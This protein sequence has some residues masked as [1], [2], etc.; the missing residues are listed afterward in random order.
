M[1]PRTRTTNKDANYKVYYSKKIPKQVRFPHRRKTVRRP[2]PVQQDGV[3]K[4]QMKFLPEMMR[5]ER[6]HKQRNSEE[7]ETEEESAVQEV[8]VAKND[9]KSTPVHQK[10]GRRRKSDDVQEDSASG[11][12]PEVSSSKRRR[13][14]AAPKDERSRTL[15]RQST[16]TQLADGRRP[17]F[18]DDEPDFRSVKRGSRAS[19][20]SASTKR[21]RDKK[22]RTLTQMIPCMGWLSKEE[23]EELSDL[24]T[25][26]K[27]VQKYNDVI[28]QP[29][30]ERGPV[31]VNEPAAMTE[32]V[33][34]YP[35]IEEDP[36]NDREHDQDD[37]PAEAHLQSF[38]AFQSVKTAANNDE[39]DYEPT[40]FIEAPTLRT[41]QTP[42]RTAKNQLLSNAPGSE[43][44]AKSRFSLLSTPEKRRVFE[45][46]S[47]QS[48]AESV[49]STQVSPQKIDRS[50]FRERKINSIVV[51][52]T[53]SKRQHVTF[54]EPTV[55]PAPPVHLRKFES[56]IQDSED[57]G[58]ELDDDTS[59]Q[60][61]S[62][63]SQRTL[64][65]QA[66]SADTQA[67]LLQIDR[68]CADDDEGLNVDYR[69]TPDEPEELLTRSIP[70]QP[71]PEL[72]GS[73]AP[74]I[75][76]DVGPQ[77]ESD[78]SSLASANSQ[79]FRAAESSKEL[80]PMLYQSH[81]VSQLDLTTQASILADD[82]PS[83]PPMVRP[84]PSDDLPSTPMVIR[85]ESS[86]EEE[87]ASEPIPPRT[88]QRYVP[89][90]PS[91]LIHQFTDLDGEPVQ[92]PRSPSAERDTQQS[93]SSKAEQQLQNEWLSYSQYIRA[94][95]PNSS[96]MHVTADP[97]SY[98]ARHPN[99]GPFKTSSSRMQYSQ[100]TTVDELTPKKNRTQRP[101][102]ANTTPHRAGTSQSF[103][104]PDKPPS[105]FIPS[106]FPSLSMAAM[107]GWSSPVM[108]KTQNVHGSSQVL[109]SLEDFSIPLPPPLEDD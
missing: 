76:D 5:Q 70:C 52:E 44:S 101:T 29:L 97:F 1:T 104:S 73:W 7:E 98:N 20:V 27:H 40:Q 47:S 56:T 22:Q 96:S 67:V 46:P 58:S 33:R 3:D 26:L 55:Q 53:P 93:H 10:K 99:P 63:D 41:R 88:V 13:R 45:I 64:R 107:E 4:R 65:G 61:P 30:I 83:T 68:A 50:A 21:E 105:L 54:Q 24:D 62:G 91:T 84:P 87:A 49:M 8:V 35:D 106:S 48:P 81:D 66:I 39:D 71:S 12:E 60:R 17:S 108:A 92:V 18:G 89:E 77:Y 85:D 31:E 82:I 100:A 34:Q 23:L 9:E 38:L 28:S 51:T 74:F 59:T 78:R 86:D 94:R 2:D 15:R 95:A 75:Y 25:D 109:G 103:V 16:M 11:D 90:A 80:S 14:T 79:S 19:Q 43:K 57:E 42:R 102:S 36:H 72:G 32:P 69:D 6:T 37:L